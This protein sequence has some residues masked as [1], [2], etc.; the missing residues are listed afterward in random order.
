MTEF[1]IGMVFVAA[2]AI[3]FILKYTAKYYID[4]D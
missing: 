3:T 4:D 1:T 2:V